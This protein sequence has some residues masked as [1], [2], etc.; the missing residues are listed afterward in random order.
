MKTFLI[1][2]LLASSLHAQEVRRA[3]HPND[4]MSVFILTAN[5]V[6]RDCKLTYIESTANTDKSLT[7]CLTKLADS[8]R[9]V[10]GNVIANIKPISTENGPGLRCA[11]YRTPNM[12]M[13]AQSGVP[14]ASF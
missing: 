7:Q 4:K 9:M 14:Y 10:Q 11:I 3:Q 1:L 8:A 6:P 12:W 13:I 5:Q 2:I